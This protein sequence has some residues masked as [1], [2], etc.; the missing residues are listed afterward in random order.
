MKP[1]AYPAFWQVRVDPRERIWINPYFDHL[2]WYVIDNGGTRISLVSL[3]LPEAQ[4][5]QLVSFADESVVIRHFD[6][7]G[8]AQLSFYRVETR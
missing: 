7:S 1:A 2:H 3:P 5:P 4:R 8:A 6:E